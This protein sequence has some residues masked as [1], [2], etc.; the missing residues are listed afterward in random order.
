M[1]TVNYEDAKEYFI[2]NAR[3]GWKY[4]D[5]FVMDYKLYKALKEDNTIRIGSR[6]ELEEGIKHR[7]LYPRIKAKLNGYGIILINPD[8]E[9]YSIDYIKYNSP[10]DELLTQ[11]LNYNISKDYL[12]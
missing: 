3:N 4:I 6:I 2:N 10:I 5:C 9:E 7:C 8:F 12:E 11:L 1:R